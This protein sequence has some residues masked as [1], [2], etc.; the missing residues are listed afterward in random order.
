M[1]EEDNLPSSVCYR[2]MY[3][4]ENYYNFYETCIRA[5]TLLQSKIGEGADSSTS[6]NNAGTT[7]KSTGTDVKDEAPT[8]LPEK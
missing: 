7:V 2:C 5:Q 8:A 1:A 4:L 3:N 6:V